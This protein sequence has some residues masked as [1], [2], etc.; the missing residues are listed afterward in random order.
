MPDQMS[1]RDV[2]EIGFQRKEWAVQRVAWAVMALV[3]VAALAGLFG[4]GPVSH[5]R[6]EAADGSLEVGY[7]RFVRLEGNSSVQL[8]ISSSAVQ[9]GRT[10]LYLSRGLVDRWRI[11]Q[12]TPTPSTESS[13]RDWVILEYD[14]LG[15]TPPHIQL[16]Y[17]G[18]EPGR[19][20]GSI[21]AGEDGEPV[22]ISQ[23]IH[24]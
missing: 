18:D 1:L 22:R 9:D 12:I 20:T 6:A 23:W 17:R 5:T 11:E 16:H 2:D 4:A 10:T 3:V 14:V 21:R 24:P 8:S 7:D 15:S 13:S 19:H